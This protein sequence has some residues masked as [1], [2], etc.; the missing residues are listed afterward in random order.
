MINSWSLL[1]QGSLQGDTL[2]P[3]FFKIDLECL[4]WPAALSL[5]CEHLTLWNCKSVKNTSWVKSID[6]L[7]TDRGS[8]CN[9]LFINDSY[10]YVHIHWS[11]SCN[12]LQHS[13]DISCFIYETVFLL[14]TQTMI[15]NDSERSRILI[16]SIIITFIRCVS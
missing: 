9:K 2:N 8:Q 12:K 7:N 16:L 4:T 10:N 11:V 13:I 6:P 5:A 3:K 14:Y 15:Q 1:L